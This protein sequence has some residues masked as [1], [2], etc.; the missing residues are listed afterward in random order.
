MLSAWASSAVAQSPR[1]AD[2]PD[3][4][5]VY[6]SV[7][8]GV[9]LPGGLRNSGSPGEIS[10]LP[11]AAAEARTIDPKSDPSRMCQPL[12]VFRT[13]ARDGL[14]IE[15][16]PAPGLL[17]ILFQNPLGV[18]RIIYLNR[19]HATP[20]ADRPELDAEGGRTW[21]GDSVG[22]REGKTLVVDT[23]GFNTR[24][25]LNEAGAQHSEALHLI[26]R[27]RPVLGGQ[28]LEY[29]LTAED[30]NALAK[31]YTYTRYF[32]KLDTELED[33]ICIDEQ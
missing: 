28:Y 23:T 10:L 5:G 2:R 19:G 26:E 4:A 24:T 15:L 7:P 13:M 30:P 32:K 22:R 16:A 14:K 31:P 18:M 1:N 27:I 17:V 11:K 25:W 3:F 6:R 9:T 12:G 21:M 20:G 8:N 29:K 33:E